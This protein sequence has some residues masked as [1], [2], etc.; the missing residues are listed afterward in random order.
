MMSELPDIFSFT[1][2]L[3]AKKSVDDRA[4]NR[5][6]WDRLAHSLHPASREFPLHILEVGAGIGTMIE[7][8]IEWELVSYACYTAL[9]NSEENADVAVRRLET[10]ASERGMQVLR[11]AQSL[12]LQD[13]NHI[14][15]VSFEIAD[16]HD[17]LASKSD[18]QHWD[19]LVAHAFLDL[20]DVPTTLPGLFRMLGP[21][22][23]FLLTINFDGVSI[24]EP[25]IDPILDEHVLDLYHRA[26]DNRLIMGKPSGDSRTGRHLFQHLKSAG[27]EILS[28]GA[29]DWVVF[30]G[31]QGYPGDEAYFLHFIIHT[32]EQALTGHPEL[33]KDRFVDWI[34]ERQAQI[35]RGELVYIAHQIDFFGRMGA[36][37]P[38]EK[39]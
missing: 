34:R 15:R 10:W 39:L 28:S 31:S 8:F 4:I 12:T 38:L 30:A 7:R 33:D 36:K 32:I 19:L 21:E 26:M 5:Q 6:V 27:A 24:L 35:E 17:F 1:R 18:S 29:S 20:V 13:G 25:S 11:S 9:D 22:G 3:A 2:F 37:A 23:L 16:L 14:F